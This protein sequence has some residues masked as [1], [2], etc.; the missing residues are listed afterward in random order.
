MN[1]MPSSWTFRGVVLSAL[2]LVACGTEPLPSE[3]AALAQQSGELV[4]PNGLGLNG[5]SANGLSANGLSANGLALNGLSANGLTHESFTA[6]FTQAPSHADRMMRYIVR[7]AVPAGQVRTYADPQTQQTFT[8]E[9]GLGLAPDWAGGQP[10]SVV[11]QQV[12]TACLAAHTNKFGLSVSISI[13]GRG[14]NDQAIPF[15]EAELHEYSRKEAC[16]FGNLF[17]GEGIYFGTDGPRLRD[18]ESSS[19]ACALSS[20]RFS[21]SSECPPLLDAGRCNRI[22]ERDGQN[23][24]YSTCTV[25]GVTY[26]AL[27]TRVSKKDV[28]ECGDGV[29]Q[30]TETCGH[31]RRGNT[32]ERDCGRC[33]EWDEG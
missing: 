24:F 1:A 29:C 23:A 31:G 4:T 13:L 21:H 19:R 32:C 25:N 17:N 28:F 18:H 27:T 33:S 6:W 26:R 9:G 16:F 11:E 2:V 12:I 15:T 14:A 22:C 30:F 5:L 10:A 8:W 3:P 7:C 20:H